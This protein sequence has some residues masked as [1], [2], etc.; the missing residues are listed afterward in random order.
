MKRC[1]L[2]VLV[3]MFLFSFHFVSMAEDP[4]VEADAL[5]EKGD[6]T[7]ITYIGINTSLYQGGGSKSG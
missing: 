5:F 4:L 2:Y 7:N 3:C 1:F 6:I